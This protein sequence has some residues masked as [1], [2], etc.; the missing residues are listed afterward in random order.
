MTAVSFLTPAEL[1]DK[2]L[3]WLTDELN[4][5]AA[6]IAARVP[7]GVVPT[8]TILGKGGMIADLS[9]LESVAEAIRDKVYP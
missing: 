4:L 5:V 3:N 1:N 2:S 8:G 7:R 9:Y 6:H